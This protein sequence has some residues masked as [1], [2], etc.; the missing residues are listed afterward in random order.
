MQ[1][2]FYVYDNNIVTNEIKRDVR[3][4]GI[5]AYLTKIQDSRGAFKDSG[6]LNSTRQWE[7]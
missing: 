5:D 2:S 3:I 1:K 7:D 4:Q 6:D